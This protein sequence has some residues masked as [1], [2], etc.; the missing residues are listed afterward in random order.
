MASL[1]TSI[2]GNVAGC[3][4]V[5][6]P[7]WLAGNYPTINRHLNGNIIQRADVPSPSTY[8]LRNSSVNSV[9]CQMLRRVSESI[10]WVA[11]SSAVKSKCGMCG[12]VVIARFLRLDQ[13]PKQI[14]SSLFQCQLASSQGAEP[15]FNIAAGPWTRKKVTQF[16]DRP[17]NFPP[18][19]W[20]FQPLPSS[21][22]FPRAG[23]HSRVKLMLFTS[24]VAP[25]RRPA[26]ANGKS[27]GLNRFQKIV[28]LM[29]KTNSSIC[30]WFTLIYHI[31][32]INSY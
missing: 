14:R 23:I 25:D 32:V 27:H 20:S 17:S 6:R 13:R 12:A 1:A 3:L 31:S 21:F 26:V 16:V 19:Y 8:G 28:K 2:A 5:A 4:L 29:A 22:C 15:Q 9:R 18:I 24:V 11:P 7:A 30:P 10:C